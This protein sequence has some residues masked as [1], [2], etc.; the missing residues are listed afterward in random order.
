ME[1]TLLDLCCYHCGKTIRRG[2]KY[3]HTSPSILAQ[4]LCGDFPKAYHPKCYTVAETDAAK[5]LMGGK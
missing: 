5:Q 1:K 4:R 2:T 3:I